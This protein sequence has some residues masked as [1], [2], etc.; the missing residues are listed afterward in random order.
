MPALPSPQAASCLPHAVTE[1]VTVATRGGVDSY[2]VLS[3]YMDMRGEIRFQEAGWWSWDSRRGGTGGG[4]D[5]GGGKQKVAQPLT[6]LASQQY[7]NMGGRLL[8]TVVVENSPYFRIRKFP[9]GTLLPG[10]GID[11]NLL[12]ILADKLNFTY[13]LVE[14]EDGQWGEVMPNGWV[15]GMIGVVARREADMAVNEITVTGKREGVVDFST[16]YFVEG[17]ILVSPAPKEKNRAFAAF[18][19]FSAQVWG[20]IVV[21]TLV[22]GPV[23]AVMGWLRQW[24]I[25]TSGLPT[26]SLNTLSFTAFRSLVVQGN[27]LGP[28]YVPM[29]VVFFFWYLFCF[30]IYGKSRLTSQG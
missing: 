29:R 18:S 19:P 26:L 8:R 12:N 4:G 9:D 22:M 27:L 13:Q 17:T 1:I 15:T 25:G 14:A 20:T 24:A 5:G 10:D 2:Q 3:S 11:V 6:R 30:I 21:V 23:V 7:G 28:N 16:P